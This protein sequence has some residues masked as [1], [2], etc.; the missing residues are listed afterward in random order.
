MDDMIESRG[1]QVEGLCPIREDI[2][3]EAFQEIV[4]QVT[5]TCKERGLLLARVR[6]ELDA[7][8]KAY[9]TVY[10]SAVKYGVRKRL[11]SSENTAVNS[12]LLTE[13]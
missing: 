12:E 4:R 2:Y 11:S 7:T 5:L 10:E 9:K 6:E 8:K 3:S 13:M 1:A